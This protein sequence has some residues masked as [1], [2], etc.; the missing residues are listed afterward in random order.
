M[1]I[2]IFNELIRC[3]TLESISWTRAND[4]LLY[5]KEF[6]FANENQYYIFASSEDLF[7]C[8]AKI[9]FALTISCSVYSPE[10]VGRVQLSGSQFYYRYLISCHNLHT[11]IFLLWECWSIYNSLWFI[12][13]LHFMFATNLYSCVG[14][15]KL[16]CAFF[17]RNVCDRH[18]RVDVEVVKRAYTCTSL[19]FLGSDRW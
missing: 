5:L 2:H 13:W 1:L 19:T 6:V 11:S 17:L 3:L 18:S 16:F 12:T 10:T 14:I 9:I 7:S 4:V 8:H 15:S